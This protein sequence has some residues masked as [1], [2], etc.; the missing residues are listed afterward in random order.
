MRLLLFLVLVS[1][2]SFGQQPDSLLTA[3]GKADH[4][5]TRL[6]ILDAII[7]SQSQDYAAVEKYSLQ[8]QDL[9]KTNSEK[10]PGKLR[11][12][13]LHYYATALNNLAY[14]EENKSNPDG[15]IQS[16]EKALAIFK[17]IG[18]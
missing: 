1:L 7:E 2:T 15:A 11:E 10:I 14:V 16:Y 9:S 12:F 17:E 4:D 13:Y 5:T 18:D 8:M 3:F 6:K